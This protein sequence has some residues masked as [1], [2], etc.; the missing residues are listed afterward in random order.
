MTDSK[1]R[2]VLGDKDF[3]ELCRKRNLVTI[4]LTIVSLLVYFGFIFLIA[5]GHDLMAHK[6]SE[7]VTLGIP[8]GIGVIVVSWLLT[9]IYVYWAN[10]EYDTLVERVKDKVNNS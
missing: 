2:G 4:T 1:T 6:I 9:G 8:V 7:S 3:H 10:R 5:F